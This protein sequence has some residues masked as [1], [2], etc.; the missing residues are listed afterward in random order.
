MPLAAPYRRS[1]SL[2]ILDDHTGG[3]PTADAEQA[4]NDLAFGRIIDYISHSKV[5]KSS[6]IF[7][8]E[9]VAQNGVDHRD[10]ER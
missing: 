10:L 8:E 4:D 9:A 2:W 7:I 5:W 1:P 6:A 3:P